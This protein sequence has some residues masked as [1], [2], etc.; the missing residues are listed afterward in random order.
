M[1]SSEYYLKHCGLT[2]WVRQAADS[3]A[4]APD[5]QGIQDDVSQCQ[6]CSLS[7]SRC[8]TVFGSGLVT[9]SVMVVGEA[10][11]FHEDKQGQPFV[12]R[13]GRLLTEMLRAIGLDREE[14]FITNVLKCRPPE[15]RDPTAEEV[16]LC[17]P[18]LERQIQ[19]IAPSVILALGKHAA[20][21]LLATAEPMYAL[22]E[23]NQV[24]AASGTPVCVTYHP[25]YL[26]RNPKDKAKAYEDLQR[27][28]ALLS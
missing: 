22:R 11:G 18:Y 6:R 7:Q 28:L 20:H 9:A 2:H 25:A 13:A 19:S 26:L 12:G 21:H 8:N 1:P 17:T 24:H 27:V 10:P 16:A 4:P 5:W 15:N 14:V 3:A 23:R